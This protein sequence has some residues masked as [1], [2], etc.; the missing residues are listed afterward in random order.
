VILVE[1]AAWY[2]ESDA[3]L[4]IMRRLAWPWPLLCVLAVVPRPLRDWG[5]RVVAR[6]RF[7]WFGRPEFCMVPTPE[8]RERFLG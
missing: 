3:A 7:H 2:T 1:G 4:R 5:Y 8:L 6:N